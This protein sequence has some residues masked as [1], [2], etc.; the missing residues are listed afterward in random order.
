MAGSAQP[1]RAAIVVI[2]DEVLSGR[3]QDA[4]TPWLAKLLYSRGV[5]LV[6]AEYIPDD[7]DD[8][9][10]T[11]KR[12]HK[13]VGE[14]GV[15][16]TS[17]GIGPTHDDVT[18][19]AVAKAF[20][21][22]LERH[23]PTIAKMEEHYKVRGQELNEARM[24]MAT[25]PIGCE[26][27]DTPNLWVPLVNMQGVYVL[28]GIPRLFTAMIDANKELFRGPEHITQEVYTKVPEGELAQVLT[29]LAAAH[30]SVNIG[31]YPNVDMSDTAYK[32]RVAMESRDE[33]AVSEAMAALR[34]AAEVFDAPPPS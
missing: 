33:A 2:G 8:I 19:E 17:G 11:L 16:F 14:S 34:A 6:R 23:Q 15:V 1:P 3:V 4:N 10:D 21:V 18:Y 30:P 32:V 5:D 25:L 22:G 13:Q 29:S 7:I 26:V 9:V 31:S 27:L 12:L 24:K 28:P 20:G